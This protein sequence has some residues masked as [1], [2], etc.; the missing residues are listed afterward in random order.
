MDEAGLE[1]IL[2][3]YLFLDVFNLFHLDR[4]VSRY[5]YFFFFMN[6]YIYRSTGAEFFFFFLYY[7]LFGQPF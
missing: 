3:L 5:F 1:C 7:E 6:A 2:L 4:D